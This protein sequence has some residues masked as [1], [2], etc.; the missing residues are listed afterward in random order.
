M[1]LSVSVA[2]WAL[3]VGRDLF[4]FHQSDGVYGRVDLAALSGCH[5][6]YVNCFLACNRRLG[7]EPDIRTNGGL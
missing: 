3:H 1:S 2:S 6:F 5:N 4:S 7:A